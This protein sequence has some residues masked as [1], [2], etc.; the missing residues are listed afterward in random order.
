MAYPQAVP[1]HLKYRFNL[2][3]KG[4]DEITNI[5]KDIINNNASVKGFKEKA[6]KLLQNVLKQDNVDEKAEFLKEVNK[7][8]KDYVIQNRFRWESAKFNIGVTKNLDFATVKSN[9]DFY[10]K[11]FKKHGID[12]KI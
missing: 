10:N 3:L 8:V 9:A 7:L 12:Y 5:L 1:F 2:Y 6:A 11:L 4:K